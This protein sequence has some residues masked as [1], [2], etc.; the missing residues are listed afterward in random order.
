[1][2]AVPAS[3]ARTHHDLSTPQPASETEAAE[4][5]EEPA[6][7]PPAAQPASEAKP[8]HP[9][10]KRRVFVP[11]PPPPPPPPPPEE[12]PPPPPPPPLITTR[13]LQYEQ[14]H[15]L[16]DSEVQ[17]ADGHVVGRA[18]DMY[19]DASGKPRLMVVNLSGFLGVGDRKVTFPWNAFRFNPAPGK[20]HVTFAPPPAPPPPGSKT[21]VADTPPKPG[22]L[23]DV[24]PTLAQLVDS[25][26]TQK[27]GA[28]MGRV[29][30]VLIDAEGVPQALVIDLSDSLAG[31]KRQ[32]AAN[33]PDLH[34][35]LRNKAM[36]L[37]MNFTDAQI[38]AAPTYAPEQPVK[39]VSPVV[40]IPASARLRPAWTQR[41]NGSGVPRGFRHGVRCGVSAAPHEITMTID[42]W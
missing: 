36:T 9:K 39:I 34:M 30:D 35:Q 33:W 19:A 14:V 40:A 29:V 18:V 7:A 21:K 20:P 25:T 23:A 1:M 16:L 27:N 10:P 42:L 12:K 31:D 2:Y 11:K 17:R 24:P 22:S 5:E 37:Q 38:K 8:P 6:S 28:K 3:T 32:V 15:G 13:I 41:G 26:V 4:P